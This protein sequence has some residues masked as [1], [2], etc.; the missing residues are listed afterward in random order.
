MRKSRLRVWTWWIGL[1]LLTGSLWFVGGNLP[2]QADSSAARLEPD[3]KLSIKERTQSQRNGEDEANRQEPLVQSKEKTK[4]PGFPLRVTD[5][6][7]RRV[8]LR[9]QPQRIVCIAPGTLRLIC[10]LQAQDRVVGVEE[11]EKQMPWSRPYRLAHPEFLQLPVI[12]PGGVST[13]NQ[14]PPLE[15]ILA[16]HPDVVFMTYLDAPKADQMQQRLGIPVVILSYGPFASFDNRLFESLRLLGRILGK[17][18][19]AEAVVHFIQSRQKDLQRR[20]APIPQAQ[21]PKCYV[22]GIGFRGSHGIESTQVRYEPLEWLQTPTIVSDQKGKD[23]VFLDKEELLVR[24]P[25]VIF[26]DAGGVDLIRED[27]RANPAFY[28]ALRA[29]QRHRVYVLYPYNWYVT[30]IG[31]VIADAYAIGKILYPQAF[32]DIQISKEADRIYQFLLGKPVY[33]QLENHY[34]PLGAPF[35][36]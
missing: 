30:N 28:R 23:H 31:T 5:M 6:A 24:Q 19:R 36:P 9:A 11:I 13:I 33:S 15:P 29:F 7:G 2:V 25:D 32:Q 17:E 14:I 18:K 20:T 22:G 26:L 3:W 8:T 21:R 35:R 12:G 16:V 1:S 27:Y 34:G 10:Y 4:A